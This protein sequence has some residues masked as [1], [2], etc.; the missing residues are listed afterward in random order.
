MIVV[1][2]I[3]L[4]IMTPNVNYTEA[5][6][7]N[8]YQNNVCDVNQVMDSPTNYNTAYSS[9][10][11]NGYDAHTLDM[12]DGWGLQRVEPDTTLHGCN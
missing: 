6:V 12:I 1:V 7:D 2:L 11:S 8:L 3:W 9:Y 5:Q 4:G 10:I